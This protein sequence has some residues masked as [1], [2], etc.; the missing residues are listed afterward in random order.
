MELLERVQRKATNMIKE[1]E[2]LSNEERLNELGLFS[3]ENK[4]INM[5]K[6]LKWDCKEDGARLSPLVPS[7]RA[8]RQWAQTKTQEVSP[9]H[10]ERLFLL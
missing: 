1:L 7:G 5:Y 3:L 8:K 2:H 4:N 10:Q 9:E 6:Y